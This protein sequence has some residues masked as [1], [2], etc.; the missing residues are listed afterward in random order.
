M[1]A[2]EFLQRLSHLDARSVGIELAA[3]IGCVV[4]AWG[5]CRWFRRKR[6][7]DGY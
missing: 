1:Q 3:V 7:A 2:N 4:L 5:I 6:P